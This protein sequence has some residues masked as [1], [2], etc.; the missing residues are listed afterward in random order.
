MASQVPAEYQRSTST[1]YALQAQS[2]SYC[3]S[4][5]LSSLPPSPTFSAPPS[6]DSSRPSTPRLPGRIL[7]RVSSTNAFK[8]SFGPSADPP[9]LLSGNIAPAGGAVGSAEG[10]RRRW[11]TPK[12]PKQ[13]REAGVTFARAVTRPATYL[14]LAK[15]FAKFVVS[16]DVSLSAL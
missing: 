1:S 14:H 15:R 7:R 8:V 16:L 10:E 5:Q 12:S 4:P 3:P 13:V 2:S 11:I 9:A 6:P